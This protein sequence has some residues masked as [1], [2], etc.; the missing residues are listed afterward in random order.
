MYPIL[1][2]AAPLAPPVGVMIS[3]LPPETVEASAVQFIVPRPVL[4]TPNCGLGGGALYPVKVEAI[5]FDGELGVGRGLDVDAHRDDACGGCRGGSGD[6]DLG[7]VDA[8]EKEG[9]I[10][11]ELD[12]AGHEA[13]C[14]CGGEPTGQ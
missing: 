13:D 9:G 11:N 10:G 6:G 3:Q 4:R 1:A 7:F 14:G 12:H 2:P 8:N 5:G